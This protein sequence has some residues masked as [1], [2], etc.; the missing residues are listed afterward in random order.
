MRKSSVAVVA[1]LL[2]LA[3]CASPKPPRERVIL[4]P[5]KDGGVGAIEVQTKAGTAEL[6]EAYTVARVGEQAPSVEKTDALTVMQR[7]GKVL[8][9]LPARPQRYTLNFEFGSD[10][11]TA[12]SRA[13]VPGIQSDLRRFPAPEVVVSGHTDAVGDPAYNDKLSYERAQ[14]VREILVGAGIPRDAIQVVGRGGREPL[15]ATKPG[16]PEPR[17]RRVEIKLR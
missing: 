13:M 16:T 3:G 10:R 4:L 17:N 8:D 9:A 1:G 12:A 5:D 7:Y 14:R 6:K 15:V 2:I 11:L